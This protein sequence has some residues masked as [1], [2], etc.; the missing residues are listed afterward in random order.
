[1]DSLY[2]QTSTARDH[3][4]DQKEQHW[5]TRRLADGREFRVV[6]VFYEP[7]AF[8]ARLAAHGFDATVTRTGRYFLQA[9]GTRR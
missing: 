7:E 2:E 5:Q 8:T 3:K 6:K 4:L 1:V 9:I